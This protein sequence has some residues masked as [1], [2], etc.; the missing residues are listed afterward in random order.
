VFLFVNSGVHFSG[1]N[2]LLTT[3]RE[4]S[5]QDI[6]FIIDGISDF[7]SDIRIDSM[8]LNF[9]EESGPKF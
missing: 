3:G 2:A 7:F 5:D 6:S 4:N 9:N 1:N 8:N